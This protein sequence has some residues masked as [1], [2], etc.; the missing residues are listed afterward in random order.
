METLN[1]TEIFKRHGHIEDGTRGEDDRLV[2]KNCG[3]LMGTT[4]AGRICPNAEYIHKS[5][6][7]REGRSIVTGK[8]IGRAHV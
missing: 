3:A 5:G 4:P 6:F 1:Y 7:D 8:Q 2:C